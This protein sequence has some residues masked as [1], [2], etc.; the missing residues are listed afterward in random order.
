[1]RYRI[2]VNP[3]GRYV[4]LPVGFGANPD[5]SYATRAVAQQECDWLNSVTPTPEGVDD[6]RVH[7]AV[8]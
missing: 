2:A 5:D 7:R 8:H 1:M 4:V 6:G 3:A